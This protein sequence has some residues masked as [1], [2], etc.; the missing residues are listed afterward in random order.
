MPIVPYSQ[1]PSEQGINPLTGKPPSQTDL[2]L[3]AAEMKNLGKIGPQVKPDAK[4]PRRTP[5]PV[6]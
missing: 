5:S 6:R 2:L 4:R 1:L 3:A